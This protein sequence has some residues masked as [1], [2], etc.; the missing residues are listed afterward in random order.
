MTENRRRSRNSR[1]RGK[2][3]N[4]QA[5][6][7]ARTA[8]EELGEGPAGAHTGVSV[9]GEGVAVHRFAADLTGYRGWEWHVVVACAPGTQQ[10]TVSEVALVPGETALQAP[11]WVPYEER[12]RPGDLGPRDLLPAAVGDERLDGDDLQTRA[13]SARGVE[14]TEQR[15]EEGDTGPESDFAREALHRCRTCAFMV[16]LT[17]PLGK[18]WGVCVNEWTFDATA[19]SFDHGCGAHSAIPEVTGQGAPVAEPYQ[20]SHL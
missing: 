8:I 16:P 10:A 3:M 2:V 5:V 18:N 19:V 13:L 12:L 6:D 7:T 11:E 20:D 1:R 9:V 15:W 14:D 17:G 4:H